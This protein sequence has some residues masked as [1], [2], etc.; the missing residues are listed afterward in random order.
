[1]AAW[2]AMPEKT[3]ADENATTEVPDDDA[4]DKDKDEQ[5]DN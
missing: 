5:D 2:F 1:V 4:A 3:P